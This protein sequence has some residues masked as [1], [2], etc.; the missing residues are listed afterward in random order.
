MEIEFMME[1]YR[2]E[3]DSAI[4]SAEKIRKHAGAYF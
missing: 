3:F 2:G 1:V 4:R